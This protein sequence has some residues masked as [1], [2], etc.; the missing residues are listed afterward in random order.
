MISSRL[1]TFY[2]SLS[3][4]FIARSNGI[5]YMPCL[6][7]MDSLM[8][9]ATSITIDCASTVP[10]FGL[11]VLRSGLFALRYGSCWVSV[12]I[13]SSLLS[14]SFSW[15][16]VYPA[17][18]LVLAHLRVTYAVSVSLL[19]RLLLHPV[20]VHLVFLQMLAFRS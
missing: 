3:S 18:S 10:N 4:E 12:V 2:T 5:W 9:W 1:N 7:L 14:F 20:I 15:R 6:L 19:G 17:V 11:R 16:T 8:V 13:L